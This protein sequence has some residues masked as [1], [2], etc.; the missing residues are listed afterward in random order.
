MEDDAGQHFVTLDRSYFTP[1]AQYFAVF[2]EVKVWLRQRLTALSQ[3]GASHR[4]P[5]LS[6]MN[7]H[8]CLL[9]EHSTSGAQLWWSATSFLVTWGLLPPNEKPAH[10][11]HNHRWA[12]WARLAQQC[13]LDP[14]CLRKP[15]PTAHI[16]PTSTE[17]SN[18]ERIWHQPSI[19]T[20]LL[21]RL[22]CR[23]AF[24]NKGCG[25]L[26]S[27]QQ[28]RNSKDALASILGVM[29][30]SSSRLLISPTA[31][32]VPPRRP[33]AADGV[34][35]DCSTLTVN[36]RHLA[37]AFPGWQPLHAC[38]SSAAFRWEDADH[39][40]IIVL[41]EACEQAGA[42]A[43]ALLKQLVWG[44]GAAVKQVLVPE[45]L[46]KVKEDQPKAEGGTA[47]QGA[48][49]TARSLTEPALHQEA[50]DAQP[51]QLPSS[52]S[53]DHRHAANFCTE[54]NSAGEASCGYKLQQFL[55]SYHRG[56]HKL[57]KDEL[58]LSLAID[59]TRMARK[60]LLLCAVAKPTGEAAWAPPQINND[61]MGEA[62]LAIL[63][64][65]N[66]DEAL[67]QAKKAQPPCQDGHTMHRLWDDP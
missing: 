24:A 57:F 46:R 67:E 34:V 23:W 13:G 7:A 4:A 62:T 12:A 3:A 63:G 5:D 36:Y 11:L 19:A 50:Q 16:Q 32:W 60:A 8:T 27:D 29:L 9:M 65:D 64:G 18:S 39:I 15:S 14:R 17:N 26:G 6:Q 51:E 52:S 37:T 28:Q 49:E 35:V 22:L 45:L 38:A 55:D 25:R 66:E 61:Y 1:A 54:V 10:A 42:K 21:L 47:S 58:Q 48:D 53:T 59:G 43:D 20:H 2:H 31:T 40:E 41:M 33:E 30:N 44:I 56:A